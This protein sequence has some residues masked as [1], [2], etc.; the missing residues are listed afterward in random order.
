LNNEGIAYLRK[1][2]SGTTVSDSG[3]MV[4]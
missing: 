2:K 3:K 4:E 1:V